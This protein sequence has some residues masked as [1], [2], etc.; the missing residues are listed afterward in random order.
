MREGRGDSDHRGKEVHLRE[1]WEE[2]GV[3]QRRDGCETNTNAHNLTHSNAHSNA[4]NH[5]QANTDTYCN[6]DIGI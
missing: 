1:E 5:T 4:H 2:V 3:E 6:T